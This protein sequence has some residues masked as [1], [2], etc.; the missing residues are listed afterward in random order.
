MLL[1]AQLTVTQVR[2]D[3]S[4]FADRVI[5]HEPAVRVTRGHREAFFA[6]DEMKFRDVLRAYRFTMEYERGE[7]GRYYGSLEQISDI[8]GEGDTL[9]EL[10]RDLVSYLVEYAEGYAKELQ[11]YYNAPNRRPHFPYILNVLAQQ[12]VDDIIGL[13]D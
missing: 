10:K 4:A 7:D 2:K 3:M 8:I 6:I 5:H 12:S 1:S 13:I 11:L 9:D